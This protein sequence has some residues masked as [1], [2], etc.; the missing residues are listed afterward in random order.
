MMNFLKKWFGGAAKQ[1]VPIEN[2]LVGTEVEGQPGLSG[3]AADAGQEKLSEREEELLLK[4]LGR[5]E[6]LAANT[7]ERFREELYGSVERYYST[8]GLKIRLNLTDTDGQTYLEHEAFG[9]TYGQWKGIQSIW[10]RRAVLFEHWDDTQLVNL[11][12]WQVLER[13][14][15]DRYPTRALSFQ[16]EQVVQEDFQDIR[17]IVALSKLYRCLDMKGEALRYAKAAYGLRPDLDI[18]KVEYAS[19]LHLSDARE[20][21]ELAHALINGVIEA[22]LISDDSKEIALLAYFFFGPDYIDSSIF[23]A[24]FLRA[25]NADGEAWEALAEEYYWCPFFRMEHAVFLSDGGEGLKAIAKLSS[26]ADEFP[27]FKQGVLGFVSAIEQLRLQKGD[28]V[29]MQEDMER[30]ERYIQSWGT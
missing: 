11:E 29:L 3:G 8:P 23:A 17:L 27:W 20:D 21:R 6:A 19:V 5:S 1:E 30:M 28:P 16:Q 26:L 13:W 14:I 24:H 18:V 15:K 7:P 4:M 25:G 12:K 22:K 2:N 9:G 10:D